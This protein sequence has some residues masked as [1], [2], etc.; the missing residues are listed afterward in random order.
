M[1]LKQKCERSGGSFSIA[2]VPAIGQADVFASQSSKLNAKSEKR[3]SATALVEM[4]RRN[5]KSAANFL[6]KLGPVARKDW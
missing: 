5:E 2:I 3:F 1:P 4:A 6:V